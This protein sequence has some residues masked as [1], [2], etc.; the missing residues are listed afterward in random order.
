MLG[1]TLHI[2]YSSFRMLPNP[3][4]YH[5]DKNSF[6]LRRLV[7]EYRKRI[8]DLDH[9]LVP[10]VQQLVDDTNR[11]VLALDQD[12]TSQTPGYSME[13]LNTLHYILDRCD[14]FIRNSNW[15]LVRIVIREHF[16]ETLKLINAEGE[17]TNN[18]DGSVGTR[19]QRLDFGVLTAASPEVRQDVFMDLYFYTVLSQVTGRA[20]IQYRRQQATQYAPGPDDL[21]TPSPATPQPD[22]ELQASAIWCTLVLRMMCW[23]LLHDF[24][25][26]DVQIPKSELLG[27]R[28]PVYI[29]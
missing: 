8:D 29:L 1:K 5:W 28:L 27:S 15:D 4:P 2:R 7:R 20:V 16:Q 9:P 17:S 22:L 23:L 10:L 13:L 3:T 19:D 11:L 18:D 6:N 14:D 21:D 26:D 24:H 12:Q 25:E